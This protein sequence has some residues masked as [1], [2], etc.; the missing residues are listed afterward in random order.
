[1]RAPLPSLPSATAQPR[2]SRQLLRREL[3]WFAK[4]AAILALFFV[5]PTAVLWATDK[6][7]I[8]IASD[9]VIPDALVLFE[10]APPPPVRLAV[11]PPAP[12]PP[13]PDP[14]P[15]LEP[16]RTAPVCEPAPAPRRL[17]RTQR[18]FSIWY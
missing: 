13:A 7:T 5:G 3:P 17:A 12:A 11:H 16:N 2:S 6:V 10:L 15:E 1:M 18:S 14:A 9:A 8:P 4:A